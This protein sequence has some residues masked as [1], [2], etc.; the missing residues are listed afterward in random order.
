MNFILAVYYFI[1]AIIDAGR[2]ASYL[3]KKYGWLKAQHIIDSKF[4][5]LE[6]LEERCE[7]TSEFLKMLAKELKEMRC[8]RL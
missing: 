3:H 2:S 6:G 5:E 4:K 7:S 1:V 8:I